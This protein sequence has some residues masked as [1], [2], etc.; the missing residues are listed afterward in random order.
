[1]TASPDGS[2][3][4]ASTDGSGMPGAESSASGETVAGTDEDDDGQSSVEDADTAGDGTDDD[5]SLPDFGDCDLEAYA[6]EIANASTKPVV[7]CGYVDKLDDVTE[8]QE[9]QLCVLDAIDADSPFQVLF[10]PSTIDSI[11]YGALVGVVDVAY[12]F[13]GLNWRLD[14]R[15]IPNL[16]HDTLPDLA[17]GCEVVVGELCL[18]SSGITDTQVL[19]P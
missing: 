13:H 1:M 16:T 9:A 15:G 19:C 12:S 3:T 4:E 5:G 8:W 6:A 14:E 2:G 7:D 11:S 18:Y 10:E 17:P